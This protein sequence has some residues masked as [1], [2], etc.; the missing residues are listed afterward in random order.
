[1]CQVVHVKCVL[2]QVFIT[3]GV[4]HVWRSPGKTQIHGSMAHTCAHTSHTTGLD[5]S[6]LSYSDSKLTA[7][8][9]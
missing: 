1:M 4:N 6:R 3:L 7:V 8:T 5:I 9:V 2:H